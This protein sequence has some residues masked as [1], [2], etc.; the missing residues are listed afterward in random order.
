MDTGAEG[1]QYFS[2]EEAAFAME[3]TARRPSNGPIGV[4]LLAALL[5]GVFFLSVGAYGVFAANDTASE[6]A[7][8][9][10]V[11]V[12]RRLAEENEA[13]SVFLGLDEK[14]VSDAMAGGEE[15]ADGDAYA[16]YL[17]KAAKEYIRR[18]EG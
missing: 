15:G 6:G 3:G 4:L 17:Q 11:L 14:E 1:F 7:L 2:G 10:A 12:F 18:R 8:P 9:N 16:A 13:V 5:A